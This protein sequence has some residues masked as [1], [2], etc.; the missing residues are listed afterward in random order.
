MVAQ[1]GVLSYHSAKI[2]ADPIAS[3]NTAAWA[4]PINLASGMTAEVVS[5]IRSGQTTHMLA[6]A[7]GDNPSAFA[8][9]RE[10]YCTVIPAPIA[11]VKSLV[12]IKYGICLTRRVK[13][14]KLAV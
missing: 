10:K 5:A 11:I 14:H 8:K 9:N 1:T 2:H 7:I 3:H 6:T 4:R 12:K 13:Q